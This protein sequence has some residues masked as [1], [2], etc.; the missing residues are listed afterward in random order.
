MDIPFTKMHGLGNDFMVIDNRSES[1]DLDATTIRRWSNRFTGI[2]FDQLLM[3]QEPSVEGA[4]FDYRIFNA[5]GAEVEHCGNGARCF[6]RYVTD[7]GMTDATLIPVNTS[8][9]LITLQLLDN[10]EVTVAMGV[11]NFTPVNIPLNADAESLQYHLTL[12]ELCATTVIPANEESQSSAANDLMTQSNEDL[13]SVYFG[14]VSIGNPHAVILVDD[15]DTA[16]VETLGPLIETHAAFPSG[17]NVGF[18]QILTDNEVRLRVFER[19]VGETQACGTGACAAVAVGVRQGLLQR[20]V[21]V[22]LRGG[23][24]TIV[25]PENNKTIEMTGPC[26]TVFEG[27]TRM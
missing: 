24:L 16:A 11:P 27:Q 2:G 20:R 3:V 8:G 13:G 22:K 26:S 12:S 1:Y 9:G 5:D 19:G 17:V 23:K 25:W 21:A 7:R 15:V 10:G 6:A 14:S 18:L 4:L